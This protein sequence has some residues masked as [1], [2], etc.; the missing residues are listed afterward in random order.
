VFLGGKWISG[1]PGAVEMTALSGRDRTVGTLKGKIT[2][3]G[4]TGNWTGSGAEGAGTE[5]QLRTET[6]PKC[7]GSEKWKNFSEGHWPITFAYPGS[8]HMSVNGDSITLT[9]PDASLMAYDGW[10]INVRQG[11]DAENETTDFVHC[12]D[13]WIYGYDCK[14][15]A[16]RDGCKAAVEAD[17]GGIT[18]LK[19]DQMEWRMYCRDGGDVGSGRGERRVLTFG[20]TWI[21]V[22]AEGQP[23]ELVERLVETVKRRK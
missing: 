8:W 15:G 14:C 22:E 1:E 11:G 10:E 5:V 6:Q 12:Q 21:V 23:A 3:S 9:C 7:D 16:N 2:A 17:R 4:L 18:E 19:A 20:D 13:K